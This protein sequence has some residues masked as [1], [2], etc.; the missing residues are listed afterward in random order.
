MIMI[1]GTIEFEDTNHHWH[2]DSV[3]ANEPSRLFSSN[4][5]L[6]V[7]VTLLANETSSIRIQTIDFHVS[8]LL[9]EE[10]LLVGYFGEPTI[11]FDKKEAE[12]A[13]THE[14]KSAIFAPDTD[15]PLSLN[16]LQ[17]VDITSPPD[18]SASSCL[19]GEYEPVPAMG[20]V[21][22]VFSMNF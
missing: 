17:L 15:V 7:P 1:S 19:T 4:G 13:G 21:C 11:V 12:R 2:I 18:N 16:E 9:V 20:L 3:D 10:D 8:Q 5:L 22:M 6:Y 14:S